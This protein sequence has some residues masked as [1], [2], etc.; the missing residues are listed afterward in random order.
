[1]KK[2][3]RLL[4]FANSLIVAFLP[5]FSMEIKEEEQFPL[6]QLPLDAQNI[7]YRFLIPDSE[8]H[9]IK[10][11]Q[12]SRL[13]HDTIN[14][15][16][17][18]HFNKTIKEIRFFFAS[19]KKYY[20]DKKLNEFYIYK[21]S[22]IYSVDP[23]LVALN[24]NST[25]STEWLKLY[26]CG[27]MNTMNRAISFF[28]NA[29]SH[30]DEHTFFRLTKACIPA[31]VTDRE[32]NSPLMLALQIKLTDDNIPN[33]AFIQKQKRIV[34]WL[35]QNGA[36][37]NQRSINR[38]SPLIEAARFNNTSMVK[39]LLDYKA[40]P[41][42]QGGID[43]NTPLHWAVSYENLPI[44]QLLVPRMSKEFINKP[45]VLNNVPLQIAKNKKTKVIKKVLKKFGAKKQ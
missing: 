26:L 14:A 34:Q 31:I 8:I 39:L 6:L 43:S 32:G 12:K 4:L 29:V 21:I 23:I 9:Y 10:K 42:V 2:F 16:I 25:G 27:D 33:P 17:T 36:D 28:L 15:I 37:V 22:D 44:V 19:S 38:S 20:T 7:I 1:M 30:L 40:N 13:S 45:N 3:L 5:L 41:N 35:L 18:E 11:I 24:L